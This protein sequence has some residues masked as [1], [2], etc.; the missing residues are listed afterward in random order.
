[1]ASRLNEV[2]SS[3]ALVQAFGRNSHEEDRFQREIA[4]NYESGMRSTRAAGAIVKAIAVISAA[5][6]GVTVLLGAREVLAGRLSPGELL[7]SSPT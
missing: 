6:H 2:L 3:I 5:G 7:C 1:M 4:A